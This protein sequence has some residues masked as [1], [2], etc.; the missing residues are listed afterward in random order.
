MEQYI[1]ELYNLAEHCNYGD[2]KYE[3]IRDRLVIGI[4]DLALSECLQLDLELTLEK[5]KM[6]VCQCEAV[7]EQQQILKGTG[8]GNLDEMQQ[9]YSKRQPE[10]RRGPQH[11]NQWNTKNKI[12]DPKP[13]M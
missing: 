4:Q 11:Y 10:S 7:T 5:A 3:M 1:I 8:S 2:L 9:S 13:C 12:P 6:L